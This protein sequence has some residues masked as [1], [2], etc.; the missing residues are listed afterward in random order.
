MAKVKKEMRVIFILIIFT[1]CCSKKYDKRDKINTQMDQIS[2]K[3]HILRSQ[4]SQI[5]DSILEGGFGKIHD[6]NAIKT[7]LPQ[8]KESLRKLDRQYDSLIM[9]LKYLMYPNGMQNQ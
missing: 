1:A 3:G 4:R 7:K 2:F 5:E 6:S 9:E 8:L